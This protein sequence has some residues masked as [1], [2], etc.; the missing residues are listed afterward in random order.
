[1][2]TPDQKLQTAEANE[3][4]TPERTR[5]TTVFAPRADVLET[6]DSIVVVADMPGVTDKE[7]SITLERNILTIQANQ[8]KVE[9]EGYRLAYGEFEEGDYERSFTLSEG[10][11]RDGIKATVSNGVLELTLPKAKEA[12]AR[13]IPVLSA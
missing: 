8:P 5:A 4:A 6:A 13:K 11:D 3:S 7:V 12:A 9:R 2:A 10:V 1:M